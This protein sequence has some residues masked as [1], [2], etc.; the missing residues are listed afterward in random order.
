M[1]IK[2]KF[3]EFKDKARHNG[4]A[5]AASSLMHFVLRKGFR[6]SDRTIDVYTGDLTALPLF[7]PQVEGIRFGWMP[8]DEIPEIL[9]LGDFQI[10]G[11]RVD[12]YL[13]NG[14]KCLG[15]YVKDRLAGYS[16]IH[17]NTYYLDSFDY[18]LELT[19]EQ[20]FGG[21]D[22][23]HPDFR[24]SGIHAGILTHLA[25]AVVK[26]GKT[27]GVAGVLKD[28]LTSR[29]GVGKMEI[30]PDSLVSIRVIKIGNR[31]LR[32]QVTTYTD[33]ERKNGWLK[34]NG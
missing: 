27:I 12:T 6:I 18:T 32:K 19:K 26:E 33:E 7:V 29:K 4:V 21:P 30:I 15:C 25:E 23:V 20:A 5:W 28:N 13:K 1:D 34:Q 14:S 2:R 10:N 11:E 17:F 3:S 24:G 8:P 31:I 9:S 16:W 22:F